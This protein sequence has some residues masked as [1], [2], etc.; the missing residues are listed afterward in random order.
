MQHIQSMRQRSAIG[1]LRWNLPS[2][3][4]G[5]AGR[6]FCDSD[7]QAVIRVSLPFLICH[8]RLKGH[9]NCRQQIQSIWQRSATGQLVYHINSLILCVCVCV[10]PRFFDVFTSKSRRVV[11]FLLLSD[12]P[13]R[14]AKIRSFCMQTLSLEPW[15]SRHFGLLS[16]P[17]PCRSES[18]FFLA[19]SQ[20]WRSS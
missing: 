11:R 3:H 13:G 4:T 10:C 6:A 17:G 19:C 5:G 1:Q 7:L 9:H 16:F 2:R 8:D 20:F 18:V 15:R 14:E 12:F